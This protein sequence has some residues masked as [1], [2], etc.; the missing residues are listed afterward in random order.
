MKG[1]W[2]V[3]RKAPTRPSNEVTQQY[4]SGVLTVYNQEDA[5]RPGYK[6][7]PEITPKVRLRYE[8]RRLGINRLYQARQN[9]VDISRVVR[10]PRRP[11]I[12]TQDVVITEDGQQYRIDTVQSVLDVWP[13]SLDLSLVQIT[14][15]YE[16]RP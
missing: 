2:N 1:R 13:A 6:P 12:S 14:Q 3:M 7:S 4:N 15:K 5:A 16:V 9:Q 10:I 11:G 8:E